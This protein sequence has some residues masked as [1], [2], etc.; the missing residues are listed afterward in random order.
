MGRGINV[1]HVRF[2]D[3]IWTSVLKLLSIVNLYPLFSVL[4]YLG[5]L[6]VRFQ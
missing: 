2:L 6:S 4:L 3:R 5:S 1:V